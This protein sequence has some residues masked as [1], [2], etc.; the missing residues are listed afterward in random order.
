MELSCPFGTTP[1]VPQEEFPRKPYN[2]YFIDQACS[3]KMAG[4][5]PH[6]FLGEVMELDSVRNVR[7]EPVSSAN[8]G[9]AS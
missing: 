9:V 5:W 7:F 4:Y 6:S 3:V 1:R 2:K 8:T